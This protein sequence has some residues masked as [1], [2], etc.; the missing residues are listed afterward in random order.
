MSTSQHEGAPA[1]CDPTKEP[2][3]APC[4]DLSKFDNL[5]YKAESPDRLRCVASDE[6]P[7]PLA[8]SALRAE[9]R[10]GDQGANMGKPN[11]LV[12]SGWRAEVIGRRRQQSDEVIRYTWH[13]LFPDEYPK[14]PRTSEGE[15]GK[16]ARGGNHPWQVFFQWHQ[17]DPDMPHS[18]GDVGNTPPLAF[19]VEN[20]QMV[21]DL[22]EPNYAGELDPDTGDPNDSIPK[23][24]WVIGPL[25]RGRWHSFRL[26]VRWHLTD[27][28]LRAW[29]DEKPI[30][31]RS[32]TPPESTGPEKFP[33]QDTEELT[34]IG[35]LFPARKVKKPDNSVVPGPNQP[36][37][38]LKAGLYRQAVPAWVADPKSPDAA[39]PKPKE[40]GPFV[41]YH[42]EIR[43]CVLK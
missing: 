32:Q 11:S 43:Q 23:G 34:G 26:E 2:W 35:T 37:V 27:G 22:E 7:K 1:E 29:H 41:V 42:D 6:L 14:H 12:A 18:A 19:I 17:G 13:T 16:P 10:D 31:F 33:E 39:N 5:Q 40:S 24:K 9:V 8:G 36:E 25:E 28:L 21:L 3:Y 4:D 20:D 38:Y 30:C 15:V